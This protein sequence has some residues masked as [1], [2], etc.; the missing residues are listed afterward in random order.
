MKKIIFLAGIFILYG[1]LVKASNLS[2]CQE[3]KHV[4]DR[5]LCF[6][7]LAKSEKDLT[8]C[9][10]ANHEGVRYQCYFI[11]AKHTQDIKVCNRIPKR[12]PEHIK[13]REG[14]LSDL[15]SDASVCETL[16]ER[17]IKD[18]CFYK[19]F[20]KTKNKKLCLKI[21]DPGTRSMCTGK[22]VYIE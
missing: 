19:V 21:K 14:C 13:L 12:S 7:N 2:D 6:G 9:D 8:I 11:F 10:Q 16:S 18:G 4:I 1:S 15:A 3:T 17:G 5:L 22:P 20:L